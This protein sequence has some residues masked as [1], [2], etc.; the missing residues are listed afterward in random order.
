[1]LDREQLMAK[2]A[3]RI[4]RLIGYDLFSVMLWNEDSR[5]LEPWVSFQR[6]G[7]RLEGVFSIMRVPLGQGLCG[8]AAAL[9][10]AIR[11]PNVRLDPRYVRCVSG[12]EINSELVVPLVFK[13][14]L[15]GLLDFESAHYDAFS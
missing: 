14:R 3:E 6:D 11:V 12:M 7:L 2:V 15:L 9:R 13:D 1:I 8:T 5:L 10:Q 4:Q